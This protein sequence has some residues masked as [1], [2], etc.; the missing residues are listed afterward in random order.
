MRNSLPS[1][2]SKNKNMVIAVKKLRK[3]RY[4]RFLVFSSFAWFLWFTP[5]IL[6]GIAVPVAVLLCND[7]DFVLLRSICR[8]VF[9]I[10]ATLKNF[11]S[12]TR[13]TC[14]SSLPNLR[15]KDSNTGVFL[16]ILR[17]FSK[18][19]FSWNIF[20]KIFLQLWLKDLHD[21]VFQIK[22]IHYYL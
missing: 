10:K 13:N 19:D 5:N 12:F 4:Q 17:I 16:L 1:F 11:G 2:S 20:H 18:Q 3:S 15:R 6:S 9:C 22:Y 8:K 7:K 14:Y 21:I